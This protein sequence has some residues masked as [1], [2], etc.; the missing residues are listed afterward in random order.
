MALRDHGVYVQIEREHLEE[1]DVDRSRPVA[2][3]RRRFS[4]EL[5]PGPPITTSCV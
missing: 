4:V 1:R 3:S 2:D 5:L